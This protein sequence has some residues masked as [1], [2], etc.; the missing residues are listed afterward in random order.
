MKPEEL[1]ATPDI[2]TLLKQANGGLTR[3]LEA[4]RHSNDLNVISFLEKY[5]AIPIGD[6]KY[7]SWEAIAL[8]AEVDHTYLL[9]GAILAL[10]SYSAN[11]V[12]IIALSNHP[13]VMKAR[14]EYAKL[15]G[16]HRDRDAIQTGLGFLPTAKG[17]TF[18]INPGSKPEAKDDPEDPEDERESDLDH[19]FPSLSKTQDTLVPVR[20]RMLEAGT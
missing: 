6:R 14:V 19:L 17:S 7:L 3:T 15:P 18:I 4:M 16:G 1:A 9:G 8:A 5:D 11:A 10:Q 12:K 2:T 20:S 13:D